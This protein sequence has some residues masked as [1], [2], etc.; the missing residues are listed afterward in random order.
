MTASLA[1]TP[2]ETLYV[3]VAGNGGSATTPGSALGGFGGG[4]GGGEIFAL[5]GSAASGGGG[6]GASDI[7]LCPQAATDCQSLASRLI[8]AAGGGGG[9]G[10]GYDGSG[11][12]AGGGGGS[13]GFPGAK[14]ANDGSG[15]SPGT[16]GGEGSTGAGGAAGSPGGGEGALGLGGAGS[17]SAIVGGSGGGG[18]GGLY[19]GGGG[20][21]GAGHLVAS[22]GYG[23]GGGG[24]A[25]GSSGVPAGA[26]GISNF[27]NVA[28]VHGAE[29]AVTISWMRPPPT[30]IT[31]AASAVTSASATVTGTVDPNGSQL[32]DC[33]FVVSSASTTTSVP[34]AQQVGD[35]ST[36]SA[37]SA[38]LAGLAPASTYSVTLSASSAQG[39]A[40]GSPVAFTTAAPATA[41]AAAITVSNL[42]LS[43]TRFRR[44]TRRATISGR[45]AKPLP[46]S[47]TVSFTLSAPA[48]ISLGFEAARPG[49]VVGHSC[50]AISG[51][52]RRGRRCTRYTK[53]ARG[54][55]LGGHAGTDRV[56]FDGLLDGGARL[57]SGSYRLS[58]SIPGSAARAPQR[59]TF[60][61]L[62]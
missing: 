44:G 31:G 11:T 46:T 20:G 17:D 18:G 54:V 32:S 9:G 57:P 1:V 60:T 3:E 62:A 10:P 33:H 37:V 41:P 39:T 47:T 36:P 56:I 55:T 50:A 24:G 13:A 22:S 40:S 25:G 34:C 27:A 5:F 52:H 4:S 43:N 26:T 48:V 53:V 7:R 45:R 58:L 12:V 2:G 19:G 30:V 8:V 51:R 59:P 29:P 49:V 38:G 6:G 28:S 61:L 35:A 42:R 15:D 14:G 23:S 16:G 21:A